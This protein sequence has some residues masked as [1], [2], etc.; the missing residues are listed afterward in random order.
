MDN[1]V[2]I[3]V[4]RFMQL[5]RAEQDANQLKV[6]IADSVKTYNGIN[7]DVVCALNAMYCGKMEE[8]DV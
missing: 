3:S 4:E 6:L 2:T 5:I 1:N 8:D 7:Y